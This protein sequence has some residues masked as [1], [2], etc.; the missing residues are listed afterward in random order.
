MSTRHAWIVV[1]PEAASPMVHFLR[2]CNVLFRDKLPQWSPLVF[3][4]AALSGFNNVVVGE[5]HDPDHVASIAL[6]MNRQGGSLAKTYN[7]LCVI[8]TLPPPLTHAQM[9]AI[10]LELIAD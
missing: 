7:K 4:H 9:Q 1:G 8:S 3:V 2:G 6:A 5:S 10:G